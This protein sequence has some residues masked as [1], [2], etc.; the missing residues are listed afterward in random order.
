VVKGSKRATVEARD[1]RSTRRSKRAAVEARDGR[2]TRR[3]KHATVEA[4]GGLSPVRIIRDS[5][6]NRIGQMEFIETDLDV[7]EN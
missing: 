7:V 1:G 3:S 4:R 5:N 6:G 2:S